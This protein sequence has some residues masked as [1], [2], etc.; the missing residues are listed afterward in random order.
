MRF[1][2]PGRAREDRR[3]QAVL[4]DAGMQCQIGFFNLLGDRRVFEVIG[5]DRLNPTEFRCTN[6]RCDELRFPFRPFD[7]YPLAEIPKNRRP[8]LLGVVRQLKCA[9]LEGLRHLK[10]ARREETNS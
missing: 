1:S 10:S 3:W 4:G 6:P 9:T 2:K 7:R 8:F 5:I